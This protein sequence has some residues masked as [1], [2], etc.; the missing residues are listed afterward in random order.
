MKYIVP[1]IA[2]ALLA[3][4]PAVRAQAQKGPDEQRREK[5]R[6]AYTQAE[7]A[8]EG[9]QGTERRDC[10]MKEMCAQSKDAKA[11]EERMSKMKD[12]H[13]K[14]RQAHPPSLFYVYKMFFRCLLVGGRA[15]PNHETDDVRFFARTEL[16]ELDTERVTAAQVARMFAH[17]D[18]PDLP[19]DFD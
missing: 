13:D 3:A 5:M 11:C 10:M 12:A 2:A 15:R 9:K 16:P 4:A 19:T 6:A 1:L 14:A 7:K 8:C 17:L 18:A